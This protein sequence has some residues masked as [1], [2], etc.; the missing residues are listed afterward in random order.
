MIPLLSIYK[1]LGKKLVYDQHDLSPELYAAKFNANLFITRCL[2]ALE[3]WS[4]Y[5]AD[6]V[7]VTNESYKEVA[8][9]RGRTPLYK[10][11]VLRN[12][13]DIS[14]LQVVEP[15]PDLSNKAAIIIA[16]VG[17]IG[18]QD[19]L[20]SICHALHHLRYELHRDDFYCVVVGDGDALV[21]T[22]ALAHELRVYD[23]IWFAG[24]ISDPEHYSRYIATADICLVPDPLND[25]NNRSTFVK[26]MEYMAV[27]KPVV[28][29]DLKE[30]RFSAEDGALYARPNDIA[31]FAG[32]IALLMDRPELRESMGRAGAERI[33]NEL[34][35]HFS[36]PVLL[37]VYTRLVGEWAANPSLS[38]DS[39]VVDEASQAQDLA[40]P[41]A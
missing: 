31:D 4:Y 1:L 29:F 15:D 24:W 39:S 35:W 21:V 19:G 7:I 8:I 38:R 28:G 32:K 5:L 12:G 20:G 27:G 2:L 3:R 40:T 41:H 26:I 16:F 14:A 17:V 25:Y 6:H 18:R 33:Q 22:K 11:S 10:V 30:S 13:P 37:N 9:A 23:K 36:V 34:A